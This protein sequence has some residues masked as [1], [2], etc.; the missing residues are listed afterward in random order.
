L[1]FILSI[2]SLLLFLN[3]GNAQVLQ[4][5]INDNDGGATLP[6]VIV[7]NKT[8][9]QTTMSDADGKYAIAAAQ[10]DIIEFSYL[11]YYPVSII[12]P[13]NKDVFRR[14]GMKKKLYTIGEVEIRPDWTP[15]QLDSMER[16]KT[17]R[18]TLDRK[19]ERSVFSPATAIA[20]NFSKKSKQRW[21]FQEN[22][23]KWEDRK[24]VDTRYT[25]E[26]VAKL[27]GLQGDTLAAFINAYPMPYDYARTATDLEIKM[28]I[29]YNFREW[30]KKPVMIVPTIPD[31]VADSLKRK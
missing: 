30:K 22:F 1:K 2:L 19:K 24:F 6:A 26:E 25:P 9:N 28:W 15:Y 11:G 12:M 7:I 20:E 16:R 29:K 23:A 3:A 5:V 18:L 4:G 21:R 13:E 10:N 17:Y 14:V 8:K 31:S 27:T